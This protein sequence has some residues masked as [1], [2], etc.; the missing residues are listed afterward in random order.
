MSSVLSSIFSGV[1]GIVSSTLPSD[2]SELSH[3]YDIKKNKFTG[4]EK[5]FG[6]I[7][8][9]VAELPGVTKANTLEQ[10]YSILLTDSYISIVGGDSGIIDKI[11]ELQGLFESIFTQLVVQKAGHPN[12]LLV[13]GFTIGEALVVQEE[14]L[15]IIEGGVKVRY[16][17]NF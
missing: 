2:Y 7:P 15:I 1:K 9:Q 10:E 16:R 11:L 5:R 6:V 17:V 14:K 13:S 8:R 3:V 4:A 12:C